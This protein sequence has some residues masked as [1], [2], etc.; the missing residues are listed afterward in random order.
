MKTKIVP[1][2]HRLVCC[3]LASCLATIFTVRAETPATPAPPKLSGPPKVRV[4]VRENN[5]ASAVGGGSAATPPAAGGGG[6]KGAS[7]QPNAAQAAASVLDAER[8]T[9]TTKKTLTVTLV[10]LTTAS[11]DVTAKTTFLAKDEAGKHEMVE[12]KT[13]EKNVTLQPGKPEEFTTEEVSFT[14]TTAHYAPKKAGSG[15]GGRNAVSPM[16]PAS[17]H[18]YFGYKVQVFQGQDLVGLAA[19]ET[20]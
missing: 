8:F 17:G 13:L 19:S 15:G 10:N 16:I 5:V 1:R 20:H 4:L 2:S 12:E 11:M 14:H 6:A 7:P 3:C 18:A 9:R